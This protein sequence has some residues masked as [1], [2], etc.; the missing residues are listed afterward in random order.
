MQAQVAHYSGH[1]RVAGQLSPAHQVLAADGHNL[2]A[3]NLVAQLVA[4][5]AA[6]G[7]AVKGNAQIVAAG[8]DHGAQLVQVGG[9]AAVV[10]VHAVGVGVDDVG[11]QLGE[12]VKQPGGSG[13][14]GAVGAVH[15]NPHARQIRAHGGGQ[16]VDVVLPLLLVGVDDPA[17]VAV[18]LQ[19][20]L[21]AGEDDVLNLTLQGV[22]ELE[23]LTVEDLDAV[24]LKGVVGGGDDDTGVGVVVHRDPGHG[25]GGNDAQMKHIGAGGAQ[26]GN[27]S[28]LQQVRGDAGVLADGH[29][30][31]VV[32]L[33]GEHLSGGQAHLVG[34]SGV[35]TGVD[36][37]ADSVSTKQFSHIQNIPF[38]CVYF[39]WDTVPMLSLIR[40]TAGPD[41][42][43]GARA[44][45]DAHRPG[46]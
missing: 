13:G 29:Q 5:Q 23:A 25:R 8:L 27:Q 35:Q 30:R 4:G 12:T 31:L 39:G 26:S 46:G 17:D 32:A 20:D 9:A 44:V 6:V 40:R 38:C 19:G 33:S 14:R 1:H 43:H 15:Q 18:G 41:R 34:Q 42:R 2:V 37:A 11:V 16:M 24:V 28:T 10:D 36:H 45:P 21:L 3:V 22:G 7:V